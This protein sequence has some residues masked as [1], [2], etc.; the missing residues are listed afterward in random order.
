MVTRRD[1]E[2]PLLIQYNQSFYAARQIYSNNLYNLYHIE[3][4]T[5]D[6]AHFNLSPELYKAYREHELTLPVSPEAV[7]V[8][9]ATGVLADPQD[10][11]L[12]LG[13]F[14]ALS[15]LDVNQQNSAFDLLHLL[16][17]MQYEKEMS[18]TARAALQDWRVEKQ[19]EYLRDAGI[20]Y[21]LIDNRWVG[22]LSEQEL[23]QINSAYELIYEW[24]FR[25]IGRT[26]YLYRV[27]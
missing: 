9:P 12:N 6:E 2:I 4:L 14:I 24:T 17:Q 27:P 20:D 5:V 7:I 26:Y 3:K 8:N 1:Q 11:I 16:Q 15:N 10:E 25:S 21:L 23:Q 13:Y 19:P 22:F 18:D